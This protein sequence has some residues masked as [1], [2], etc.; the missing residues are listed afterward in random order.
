MMFLRSFFV[1]L[2]AL[3][4]GALTAAA[5][6]QQDYHTGLIPQ[7]RILVP[8]NGSE[9]E[10]IVF[11]IS[12]GQG[13]GAREDT[14]AQKLLA[15]GAAVVGID[16]PSYIKSLGADD[17]EC[18]YMVSDIEDVSQQ[19]QRRI[20]NPQYRH[21]IVAGIGEGGALALAMISQS[22]NAT[23]DEAIAVDPLAGVPLAKELCTPASKQK[24]GDRTVY[25]FDD[26]ALPAAVTIIST[27]TADAAG[28]AHGL[29]LK[30]DHP[31]VELSN[32]SETSDVALSQALAAR[33][34]ATGRTNQPL[35]LPLTVLQAK[36]AMNTMAV[37]FS[38]DGGWR[39]L[40]SEVGGYLQ[41]QGIPTIGLDSLRYFWSERT[42]QTTADDLA[43]IIEYYRRQWG[44]QNV[45]LVGYSFGADV[46]PAAY[47][48]LPTSDRVRVKQIT[49]LGLSKEV[50]YEISVTGWLGV[51]GDG[52][53]GDPMADI[54]KIDPKLIQC[55]YG[56][57]EDDDPCPTLKDKGVEVVPIE[58]GHHFDE[59]YQALGKRI[60]DS[61][62]TRL[63]K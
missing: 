24:V 5:Q 22:P 63:S 7:P 6:D 44:V 55:V 21:P 45:L 10:G 32:S 38:G 9:L 18:V 25:G 56:T 16:F 17:G 35:D 20:G 42:P 59:N 34:T 41:S 58:G 43:K 37:I 49:L 60:R 28:K 4:C 47:N 61:L 8:N 1:A 46:L 15:A 36:P 54:V 40:D 23:I 48:L 57:D 53:G 52:K 50:D 31:E 12:G 11:L 2:A 27:A 29:R 14:E 62:Q 39:D 19:V 30:Q 26:G 3:L 13:W 33:I 51:A